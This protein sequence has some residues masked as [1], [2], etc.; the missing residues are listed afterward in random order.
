MTESLLRV[1]ILGASRVAVYAVITPARE[2]PGVRIAGVASRDIARARQYAAAHD[3]PQVFDTYEELLRS[4]RIDAVYVALPNSEHCEWAVRALEAGKHVLCEKPFASNATEADQMIAAAERSGRLLMEAHHSAFHPA[5]QRLRTIVASG[6]I[7]HVQS[8]DVRFLCRVPQ[9]DA[10]RFRYDLG[11][12]ASM[13]VGCY[14]VRLARFVT[15]EEPEVL[16]AT[17]TVTRPN[18]DGRM[19]ARLGFPSGATGTVACSLIERLW[20]FR[21]TLTVSGTNGRLKAISPWAPQFFFH[22]IS[23]VDSRGR[24]RRDVAAARYPTTYVHQLDAFVRASARPRMFPATDAKRTM[25]VIDEMYLK[26]GL[27]L[28]GRLVG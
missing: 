2:H 16:A 24:A 7:G 17:A 28:R 25:A 15:A 20:N 10:L 12:G 13:D 22:S 26:A 23:V 11:G 3:I 8:I 27:P 18:V 14:A 9:S 5:Y 19:D 4:D 6:E 1:G 21:F